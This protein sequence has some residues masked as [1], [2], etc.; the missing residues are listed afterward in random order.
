MP[1]SY[2]AR[3][4]Q[5]F[6]PDPSKPVLETLFKQYETV[7]V[8]SIVTSFGLD[9]LITDQ[10]GGDVDTIHNVR[11]VGKDSQMT[12]KNK[13]NEQA[14]ENKEEYVS[15][16][17]H[18]DSRYIDKNREASNQKKNG[19]L[20]DDYT[21]KQIPENGKYDM[22]HTISANEIHND[23]GRVLAGLSGTDLAN[24]PENLHPTDRSINRSMKDETISEFGEYLNKTE[25]KRTERLKQLHSKRQ[26]ELTDKERKELH[27]LEELNSV[28]IEKMKEID[29]R[30]RKSYNSKINAKYYT[31]PRFAKDTAAAATKRGIQMGLRQAT[32]LIFVEMWFAV[33]EELAKFK[34]TGDFVPKNLLE[35]I[36]NG[37]RRAKEK[38]KEIFSRFMSGAVAGI[39]SSLTTTLC[40][41]F[42]TTAG[43]VVRIFRQSYA[44]LVE[45]G[46]VLL[47]NPDNYTFGE[48]MRAAAKILATGASVVVGTIVSEAVGKAGFN[49][50]SELSDVVPSFCG[51]FV[52]G[53]MSCTLL[54]FLDRSK[55]MN[56]LFHA[57]DQL[58]SIEKDI[59][60]YH[61]QAAYFE[62][63][64]AELENIDLVQF[65]KET[66]FYNGVANSLEKA[67]TEEELNEVLKRAMET[68]N[69]LIPWKGYESF[70][71]CMS[72]KSAHLVFK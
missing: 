63:Y 50:I 47:I 48:R 71:A 34:E 27:K 62:K 28:D 2:A 6:D 3:V 53:I 9:F 16:E 37:F 25:L 12:Y 43:S 68:A 35:A 13:A 1:V 51:A 49:A 22:D 64:A 56:K 54:Y 4:G 69:I 30:A 11:Q 72:D 14:Y 38:Y 31:S 39:L 59:N 41:I 66:A 8:E 19:K 65:K 52:T 18:R 40:N 10:Y 29:A 15:C 32:G 24:S 26:S 58:P 55:T 33:R 42:F 23:R 45:A 21:G 46:K 36:G 67:E 57:L 61:E 5:D 44:S 60:Y 70:D 20:T 17:Y 7:L